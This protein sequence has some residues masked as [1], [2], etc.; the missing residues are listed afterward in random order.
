MTSGVSAESC[1]SLLNAVTSSCSQG[2]GSDCC[3][4]SKES[5][6]SCADVDLCAALREANAIDNVING[7]NISLSCSD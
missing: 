1:S 3:G 7:C 6:D 2:T 4:S 5:F